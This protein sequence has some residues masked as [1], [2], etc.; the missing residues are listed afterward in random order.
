MKNT[1]IFKEAKCPKCGGVA[2]LVYENSE[3]YWI[4]CPNPHWHIKPKSIKRSASEK[5]RGNTVFAVKKK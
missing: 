5:M 1:Y 2:K 3:N 4:M